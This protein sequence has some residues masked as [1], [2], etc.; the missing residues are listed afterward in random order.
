[1]GPANLDPPSPPRPEGGGAGELGG[2]ERPADRERGAA[3]HCLSSTFHGLS[4]TFG[5]LDLSL[6]PSP[7]PFTG[8]PFSCLSLTFHCLSV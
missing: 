8:C 5:G 1:M 3:I 4:L 7:L 6:Q 2:C